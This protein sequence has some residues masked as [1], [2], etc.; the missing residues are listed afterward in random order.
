MKE[1]MEL[2]EVP[3][4]QRMV[5]FNVTNAEIERLKAE[6][7]PLTINGLEDKEG[8]KRV[9]EARQE[10]KRTRVALTKYAKEMREDAQAWAKKVISEEKRVVGELETIEAHL[11]AEEDKIEAEK[12]RIRKEAEDRENARMQE[13]LDAL[14]QFGFAAD[15]AQLKA[16]DDDSFKK[17][18]VQAEAQWQQ[19]QERKA[20]EE[21]LAQLER[22]RI[23]AERKELEEL[24]SKQAEQQR[25]I[26]EQNRK[27]REAQEREER[28]KREAEAAAQRQ[29]EMAEARE[30]AAEQARIEERARIEREAQLKK[31]AEEKARIAAEKKAERMPDKQR[32]EGF[33][34][35]F[36]DSYMLP[37]VKTTEANDILQD[38]A[39]QINE[40]LVAFEKRIKEL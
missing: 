8:L 10:V 31:E 35:L 15:Y 4:G 11:Q 1:V 33:A 7:L 34:K 23:E 9:Y 25:I 18:L 24:R 12:D 32:L 27:I 17:L 21:R 29:K 37:K 5:K 16:L 22:D 19:E 40:V 13:R 36:K 6:Y 26:D 39:S 20:E 14:A 2:T 28:E 38:F 30:R 3:V